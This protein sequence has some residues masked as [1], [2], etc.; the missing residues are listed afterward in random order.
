MPSAFAT[1]Y[2]EELTKAVE[3]YPDEYPWAKAPT[4]I[5][6]N[7]GTTT[8]P[9]QTVEQVADK[10]LD[11]M[12]RGTYNK[13]SRAIKAVCKRLGIPHTYK[14]LAPYISDMKRDEQR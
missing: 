11:A 8:L 6:G 12:M 7:L 13:D 9:R 10:M 3:A 4:V 2:R 1:M 14:A 5:H